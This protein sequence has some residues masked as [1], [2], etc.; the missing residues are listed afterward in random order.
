MGKLYSGLGFASTQNAGRCSGY[1]R[2]A[3]A[4]SAT[5]AWSAGRKLGA[6]SIVRQI[7][8]ISRVLRV[9]WTIATV[10]VPIVAGNSLAV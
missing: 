8:V 6:V 1:V 10:S 2:A 7:V 9:V 5:A 3:I 4:A